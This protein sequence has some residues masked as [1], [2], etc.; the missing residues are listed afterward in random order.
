MASTE[1]AD[2]GSTRIPT[3]STKRED[4]ATWKAVTNRE[5]ADM[6]FSSFFPTPSSEPRIPINDQDYPSN[7]FGCQPITNEK[8]KQAICKLNPFKVPGTNGIP[9][10][11]IKQCAD[12]LIPYTGPIFRATF[13][14][15]VYPNTWKDSVTRVV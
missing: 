11:V 13:T 2:G 8:I 9:N 12:T 4:R 10:I 6:L 15:E 14:L 7:V 5:K 1:A 3:L